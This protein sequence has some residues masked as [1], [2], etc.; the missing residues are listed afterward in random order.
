MKAGIYVTL[1]KGIHD[2]QGKAI[3]DALSV[4][5]FSGVK[6]VRSGKYFE[7]D[8]AELG[9]EE[10]NRSL[11]GMCEKLLANTVIETYQYQIME[12]DR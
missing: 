2:P 5:G 6:G 9:L 3:S 8:L 12:E 1:K 10:A 7:I 11:K 4:L